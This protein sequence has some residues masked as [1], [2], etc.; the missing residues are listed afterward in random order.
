MFTYGT[1]A[2]YSVGFVMLTLASMDKVE[3]VVS[4]MRKEPTCGEKPSKSP[5]DIAILQSHQHQT[6]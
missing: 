2:E 4:N 5:P 1:R 6:P 3:L